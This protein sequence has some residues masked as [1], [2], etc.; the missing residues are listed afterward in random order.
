[1]YKEVEVC[2]DVYK[3]V[4]VCR[5]VSVCGDVYKCV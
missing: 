3:C 2:K 1:M 4:K 5:R